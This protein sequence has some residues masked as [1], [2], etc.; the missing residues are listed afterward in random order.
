MPITVSV[1]LHTEDLPLSTTPMAALLI[2]CPHGSYAE[3]ALFGW[4]SLRW[5]IAGPVGSNETPHHHY[6]KCL[7]HFS[8]ESAGRFDI[9]CLSRDLRCLDILGRVGSRRETLPKAFF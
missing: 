5:P 2:P 9:Y 8:I 6:T 1:T 4:T 3:L 7:Q